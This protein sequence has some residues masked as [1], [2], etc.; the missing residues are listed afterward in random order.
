MTA[1]RL[2]S[3]EC[4]LSGHWRLGRASSLRTCL[5]VANRAAE[6][7]ACRAAV[8]MHHGGEGLGRFWEG[9]GV[10]HLFHTQKRTPVSGEYTPTVFKIQA[11]DRYAILHI[12]NN[13]AP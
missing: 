5:K 1:A 2:T 3:V 13:L 8:F 4:T 11:I 6:P 12:R 7:F 9:R 10:P